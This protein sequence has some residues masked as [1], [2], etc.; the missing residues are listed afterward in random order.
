MVDVSAKAETER[1]AVARALLRCT[2]STRDAIAGDTRV[3]NQ[4]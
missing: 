2:P 4:A 1:V 3:M